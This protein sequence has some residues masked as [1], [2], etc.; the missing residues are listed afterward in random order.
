[1]GVEYWKNL[2]KDKRK[3]FQTL[4]WSGVILTNSSKDEFDNDEEEK[5]DSELKMTFCS[6]TLEYGLCYLSNKYETSRKRKIPTSEV[7]EGGNL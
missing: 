7:K 1:V 5:S 3:T 4:G 2:E 6:Q